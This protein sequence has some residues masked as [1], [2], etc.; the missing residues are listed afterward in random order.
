MISV[1]KSPVHKHRWTFDEE[2]SLVEFIGI[3]K[4]DDQY[5]FPDDKTTEWP[6]FSAKHQFWEDAAKHIQQATSS[7]ILLASMY[8]HYFNLHVNLCTHP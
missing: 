3:A 2:R 6:S 8:S 5:G 7:N 4:T 1:Y